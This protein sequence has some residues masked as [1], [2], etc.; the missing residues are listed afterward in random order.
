MHLI[1][2]LAVL[3]SLSFG[4]SAPAPERSVRF[5]KSDANGLGEIDKLLVTVACGHIS[6][7]RNI[8]EL[9][10]IEMGYDIPTQNI[11]EARPRLGAAAVELSRWDGVIS[12]VSESD[13][14]FAVVVKVEGRTG[15]KQW[16]GPQLG[17]GG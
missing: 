1:T 10:S 9:Y 2:L 16:T 4:V 13:D 6:S 14:C 15:K 3:T 8:P 11:F 17:I 12:V 5:P 7:L